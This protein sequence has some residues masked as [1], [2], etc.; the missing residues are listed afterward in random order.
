V[1]RDALLRIDTPS[2]P[3]AQQGFATHA[4]PTEGRAS[5]EGRRKSARNVIR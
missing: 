3:D 4:A 5:S 1:G 2:P